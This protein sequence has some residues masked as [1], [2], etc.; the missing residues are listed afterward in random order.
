MTE[1]KINKELKKKWEELSPFFIEENKNWYKEMNK[2]I[3]ENSIEKYTFSQH[4][5]LFSNLSP[6]KSVEENKRL[7]LNYL[8]GKKGGHFKTQ[9]KKCDEIAKLSNPRPILIDNIT[10][11]FKTISF[12][13]NIFN[14]FDNRFVTIDR[15]IH[16]L[17]Y[18]GKTMSVTPK[19]YRVISSAIKK[20]AREVDLKPNEV[21]AVLWSHSKNLYGNNI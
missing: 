17:A 18:G 7:F 4:C 15:H 14:P 11:G 21:Q 13:R 6:M 2:W 16:K 12:W 3:L 5:G 19:R 10:N 9:I 20:I 8:N 1:K